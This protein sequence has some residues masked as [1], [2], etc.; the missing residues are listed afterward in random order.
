ME[1]SQSGCRF[2]I[3]FSTKPRPKSNSLRGAGQ[4][5]QERSGG[6]GADGSVAKEVA[7]CKGVVFNRLHMIT[8]LINAGKVSWP[9]RR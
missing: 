3:W 6:G 1:G 7:A 8:P 4:T 9:Q 2:W 5:R